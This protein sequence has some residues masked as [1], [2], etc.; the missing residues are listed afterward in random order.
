MH[1]ATPAFVAVAAL[2]ESCD[3]RWLWSHYMLMHSLVH[4]LM[5]PLPFAAALAVTVALP[6]HAVAAPQHGIESTFSEG[7]Q[8]REQLG[9]GGRGCEGRGAGEGVRMSSPRAEGSDTVTEG[10]G[11]TMSDTVAAE[12]ERGRG[13]ASSS[14]SGEARGFLRDELEAERRERTRR[15]VEDMWRG[16]E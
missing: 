4:M 7:C 11:M 9:G 12:E 6:W 5:H 15:F 14:L 10:K 3:W 1:K 2:G 13:R 8:G 16:L